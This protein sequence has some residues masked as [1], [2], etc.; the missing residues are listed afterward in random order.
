MIFNWFCNL[1]CI[2]LNNNQAY[3]IY[4][5]KEKNYFYFQQMYKDEN[6]VASLNNPRRCCPHC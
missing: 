6:H 3:C 4:G 1:W 5:N 2:I